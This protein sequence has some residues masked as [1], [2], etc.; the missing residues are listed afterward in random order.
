M[1]FIVE[2]DNSTGPSDEGFTQ[3]WYVRDTQLDN[4]IVCSCGREGDAQLIAKLLNQS[5]G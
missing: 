2:Y 1:R 5:I 4:G 3:W